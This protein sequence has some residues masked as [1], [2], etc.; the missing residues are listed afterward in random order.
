MTNPVPEPPADPGSSIDDRLGRDHEWLDGLL[1]RLK[2]EVR[3]SAPAA[4]EA[5]RGF[6]GG[7]EHHMEWEDQHLFPAVKARASPKEIR[8]IESLEIDHERLRET[9]R[10]LATSLAAGDFGSAGTLVEWLG[11]LLEGH[12]YDEEHGV[13][14]EADRLLGAADRRRL[15]E[16]FE[17]GRPGGG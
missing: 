9:L 4:G 6:T 7:L 17:T 8:S 1:D 2:A 14:V 11:T 5:L 13:Y 16:R 15:I 3:S 10:S 12:N